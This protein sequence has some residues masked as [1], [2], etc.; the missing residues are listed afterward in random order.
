MSIDEENKK[1]TKL[2]ENLQELKKLQQVVDPDGV[3][4]MPMH[5]YVTV[6]ALRIWR[7][8]GGWIY[9][10]MDGSQAPSETQ[11]AGLVFVPENIPWSLEEKM[12][13]LV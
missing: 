2:Q 5:T 3:M 10:V 13:S 9:Q 12:A 6:G 4:S 8:M 7:V 1:I 11:P